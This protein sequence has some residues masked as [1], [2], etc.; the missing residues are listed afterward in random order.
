MNLEDL[1][2]KYKNVPI[3]L[4]TMK[5]WVCFKVEGM[6]DGKTTKRPYN[7]MSGKLAKVN[8]HLT[9]SNFNIALMGCDKYKCDGI[10]FILGEGIFGIDLDNHADENGV[11]PMTKEEFEEF[12][13]EFIE[14]IDS[15]TELSQSGLGI[16]IICQGKLPAGAR[17]RGCVEMY[18]NGR[19]FA[20]TGNAIKNIPIQNREQEIIPLW[21]KWVNVKSETVEQPRYSSNNIYREELKLSDEEIIDAAL[22]SKGG[23]EFYRYYHDGD[24][25]LNGNDQSS[26]DMSFCNMLAFWC[27][28]DKQQMDRIFRNSALMRDKWDE[29]RGERTYGEI[30]LDTACRTVRDGYVKTVEIKPEVAVS[31]K[32]KTLGP[33]KEEYVV[34]ELT[35]EVTDFS[36]VN[37]NIDEN[38]EPIFHIKKIY[39]KYPF[40]DTGNAYQFY[41][42]FGDIFRYNVTDKIFMFWTGK[43]WIRDRTEIH[44]KYANKLIE[45]IEKKEWDLFEEYQNAIKDGDKVQADKLKSQWEES[46]KNTKRLSNKAGKDAMLA[47]LKSLYDIPIESKHFDSDDYLLNT[48]SGIVDLKTGELMP[49][50]KEK[51]MSKNTNTKVSYE[52][53]TEWLKFVHSVF[54]NGK[55][56]ET[57]EIIESLQTCLGYSLS[58]SCKEQCMFLL[59]GGGSN[60]KS[61]LTETIANVIGEYG[62]NIDSNVL[63]QQ[64]NVNSSAIYSI[65]KLQT[66][67]FVE[68]GET[69]D[70]GKLAEAQLKKLTGSDTIS[71]QYKFGNEFSYKPKFKIWMSTNNK[72][73]IRGTDL[74]I[75]RRLFLFPFLNSFTGAKKDKELP[76]RLKAE[77][78]KILGWCIKGFLK[79][80]EKGLIEPKTTKTAKEE[81]KKQMDIIAQFMEKECFVGEGFSVDSKELYTH[82]KEW[83]K[84][85]TEFVMREGKFTEEL[86]TKGILAE[87]SPLKNLVY[88]GIKIRPRYFVG[89]SENGA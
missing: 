44:R 29:F 74:G 71:A 4:K 2:N 51:L 83:A 39:K 81:Y 37:M 32:D 60:G 35:G 53:P 49:F 19:F 73:I 3:E 56:D 55:E 89:G 77:A 12:S 13:S 59:Y 34:S 21:E 69:D 46:K 63:M 57:K 42:Y 58:G 50:D 9:W 10:G 5:R 82:Y 28:K 65:A 25:S 31:V 40:T 7:A 17:R 16:H 30:T 70:G 66:A 78:D 52:E 80:Q 61:T 84:D 20:F 8:D 11:P 64:K 87:K 22:S 54:D 85:N 23:P 33:K 36:N 47:E 76:E 86:K 38:G 43:T 75:W 72:P 45:V 15:Y 18:D 1:K 67:R 68:T 14:Q 6:E 48:G 26:A 24:I 27:N 41:D 62:E 79:Y 88:K